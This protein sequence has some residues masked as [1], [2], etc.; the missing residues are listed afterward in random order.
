MRFLLDACVASRRLHSM[1]LNEGHD[2]LSAIEVGPKTTD[3]ELLALAHTNQ[4]VVITEDKD[5][6]K[7]VFLEGHSHYGIIRFTPMLVDEQVESMHLLL[8]QYSDEIGEQ[9]IIVVTPSRIRIRRAN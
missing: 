2:V 6:G 8:E 3:S 1:L 5:F 9:R 4:L 7:L